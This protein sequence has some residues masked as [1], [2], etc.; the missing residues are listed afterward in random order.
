MIKRR[1]KHLKCVET[2]TS[3][4]F[5]IKEGV[6]GE[7]IGEDKEWVHIRVQ[8]SFIYKF[9]R[10]D[11]NRLWYMDIKT[12]LSINYR[13]S[14]KYLNRYDNLSLQDKI[15]IRIISR[16]NKISDEEYIAKIKDRIDKGC[17]N[18]ALC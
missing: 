9:R 3:G 16:D 8:Q 6:L 4:T 1:V 18:N 7:V 10:A 13:L 2:H 15:S 17:M 5:T 11:L 14:K 12:H